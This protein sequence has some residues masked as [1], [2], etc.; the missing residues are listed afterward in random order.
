MRT[1]VLVVAFCIGGCARAGFQ[2]ADASDGGPPVT[3]A[4]A[5]GVTEADSDLGSATWPVVIPADCSRPTWPETRFN[6][7]LGPSDDLVAR[8]AAAEPDTTFLLSAGSYE[9]STNIFVV[10]DHV[11]IRGATGNAADVVVNSSAPEAIMVSASHVAIADLSARGVSSAVN[12]APP[13]GAQLTHPTLFNL[14]L[15][16]GEDQLVHVNS[17]ANGGYNDDGVIACSQLTF[18]DALRTRLANRDECLSNALRLHGGRNWR[19]FGNRVEGAWCP[20]STGRDAVAIQVLGGAREVIIERNVVKGASIGIRVGVQ[21]ENSTVSRARSYADASQVCPSA[22]GYIATI[23]V[24]VRNNFVSA[25]AATTNIDTGIGIN[26]SCAAVVI[27][28]SLYFENSLFSVI[29]ARY[30]N[31]QDALIY[32]NLTNRS[33]EITVRDGATIDDRNNVLNAPEEW[34][35]DPLVG[36]L[37]LTGAATGALGQGRADPNCT[38]DI[39]GQPRKT[40][41]DVGADEV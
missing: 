15:T 38:D 25:S 10:A 16:D 3:E 36:D 27:N 40:P 31:T 1:V 33:R 28:N 34:F 19:I 39:D 22:T 17:A 12:I 37:H 9:L 24:V 35:V 41:P 4:R 5:D 18:S 2:P 13:S 11:I 32:N 30:S 14:I 20:T 21:D 26:N 29:D 23:D 7:T 6:V 8:I